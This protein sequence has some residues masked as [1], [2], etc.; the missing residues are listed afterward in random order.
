MAAEAVSSIVCLLFVYKF[1]S[2]TERRILKEGIIKK[3]IHPTVHI[4]SN[5]LKFS[6]I[7]I[8]RIARIAIEDIKEQEEKEKKG[9]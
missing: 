9:M 3:K 5:F 1:I 7:G 4:S 8:A 6:I 2:C